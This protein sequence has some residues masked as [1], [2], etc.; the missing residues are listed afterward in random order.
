MKLSVIHLPAA[1]RSL[2]VNLRVCAAQVSLISLQVIATESGEV[3]RIHDKYEDFLTA[4]DGRDLRRLRACPV[5]SRF[6]VAMRS[7]QKA[8]RRACAN[9][10]RVRQ[11]RKKQPEYVKN[12][13]FRKKTGIPALRKGRNKLI[14]LHE[15]LTRPR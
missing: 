12:R 5:C 3:A 6:F 10:L 7:D 4:L 8:C 11:F 14:A 2:A 15:I 9:N 13:K 1:D